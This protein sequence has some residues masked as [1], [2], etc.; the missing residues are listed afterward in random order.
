MS[1]YR[2][3]L[4]VVVCALFSRSWA[5]ADDWPTSGHDVGRT[6]VSSHQ[7]DVERLGSR[8]TWRSP[9]PPHPAW[10]GPAERDA[11]RRLTRLPAMRDYDQAFHVISVA[12]AVYFGSSSEHAVYCLDATTGKERWT[13]V[14]DGPVR[15]AP[16]YE[17]GRVYFGADDGSAYC[18][19]AAD[20]SLKWRFRPFDDA[21]RVFH[22]GQLISSWPC[23]TGVAVVDGTAYFGCSMLPWRASYVCA[24]DAETGRPDGEGRFVKK[25]EGATLEGTLAVSESHLF[26]S[27]GRVAPR[28]FNR[29]DGSDEGQLN[30]GG[31]SL[32]VLAANDQ[33][34]HGP[35]AETR[36]G[37]IAVSNARSKA[38]VANYPRGVRAVIRGNVAYVLNAQGLFAT[39]IEKET[40]RWQTPLANALNLILA[41]D[42]L[43]LG[44][45]DSV[46]AYRATDGRRVWQHAVEGRAH[47]LAVAN[48]RLLVSTDTG[49]VHAFA[50]V[51]TKPS[52]D[53]PTKS[54]DAP[55]TSKPPL[56]PITPVADDSLI[57]RWVF[58]KPHI[59]NHVV[60]DIA[61]KQNALISGEPAIVRV[62]NQEAIALDGET[63]SIVVSNKLADANLP[64]RDLTVATWIRVDQPQRWGGL[65]GA[66][67]D[68][69]SYERGWL[70]GFE[71]TR[72]N[73]AVAGKDGDGSLTY[74]KAHA[75]FMPGNWYHVV[76]TYDGQTMNLFINGKLEAT[77]QS[78]K[79]EINYS[80]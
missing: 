52:A 17:N 9:Y 78:Q 16:T 3:D 77:S 49:A 59:E 80:K 46:T 13:C 79:G 27:Q 7:L 33:I 62:G 15:V 74:M 61:G 32:V 25:L 24:V 64:N 45:L 40:A 50:A 51:V 29:L 11:Y 44:G 12:D 20:G 36:K 19:N 72:F 23:R 26:F 70:L 42:T 75:D 22:N 54:T 41:G 30:G 28:C 6:G 38:S 2:I 65:V 71:N 10:A 39:D 5:V 8:W 73:F 63:T 14:A 60:E 53:E 35:G 68:N 76:G 67:Q 37:A 1:K 43:F 18:L 55:Q 69:G 57:G 4:L 34:V 31:G 48:G 21:K 66:I 56:A 58:Q 47:G